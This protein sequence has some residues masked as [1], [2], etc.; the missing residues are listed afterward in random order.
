MPYGL[1]ILQY[2]LAT[3]IKEEKRKHKG[4]KCE[5]LENAILYRTVIENMRAYCPNSQISI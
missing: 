4:E 3:A 2:V 5:A 1:A